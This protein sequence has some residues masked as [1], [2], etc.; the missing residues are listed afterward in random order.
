MKILKLQAE[1]IKRLTAVEITPDGSVIKISGKNASG[2]TSVLDSIWWAMGGGDNIQGKPVR[3]GAEK[4][5]ITLD[6]G[7]LQVERRF[8]Q[9]GTSLIVTNKEGARYPSP[10]SV[11][12]KLVGKLAF[13]PLEFMRL[14]PKEQFLSLLDLVP[15]GEQL[16]KLD[17]QRKAVFDQRTTVNR[18]LKQKA[19]AMVD[20]PIDETAPDD[21]VPATEVLQEIQLTEESNREYD[22]IVGARKAHVSNI[23]SM[24][25]QISD[26]QRRIK[27]TQAMVNEADKHLEGRENIDV[28]PLRECLSGIED[29]NDRAR[30]K[31]AARTIAEEHSTLEKRADTLTKSIQKIDKD[32]EKI[33]AS[34]EFPADGLSFDEGIVTYNDLPLDQASAAEQLRVSMSIAMAANPEFRVIRIT[35][36]SLMDS[37]SFAM[38]EE[39]ADQND[40]QIWVEVVDESGKVGVVIEDGHIAGSDPESEEERDRREDQKLTM[41][42]DQGLEQESDTQPEAPDNNDL[43]GEDGE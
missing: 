41:Q 40:F 17:E 35:D 1:N 24:K 28:D 20:N 34:A 15:V 32:K 36:G 14:R 39:M 16:D 18:E 6:L 37:D 27:E 8:T 13:D 3:K 10:Q 22:N 5:K 7:D 26:L 9:K 21:V 42:L 29:E 33:L 25:E 19:G 4:G 30:R 38:I 2:K 23:E 11:L 12:D 31:Q 43:F